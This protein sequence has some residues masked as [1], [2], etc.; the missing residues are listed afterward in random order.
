MLFGISLIIIMKRSLHCNFITTYTGLPDFNSLVIVINS[1]FIFSLI[2]V[3]QTP[4]IVSISKF[5]IDF[6]NFIVLSD[7]LLIFSLFTI[8]ITSAVISINK[9]GIELNSFIKQSERLFIFSL[10]IIIN[11]SIVIIIS[12]FIF[13]VYRTCNKKNCSYKNNPDYTCYKFVECR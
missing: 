4:F 1:L 6:N 3:N 13:R 8:N 5:G 10:T 9:F 11:T 2:I 7:C 12:F